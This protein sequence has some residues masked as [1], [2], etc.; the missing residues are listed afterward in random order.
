MWDVLYGQGNLATVTGAI[1]FP[2]DCSFMR[3]PKFESATSTGSEQA[4]STTVPRRRSRHRAAPDIFEGHL[5]FWQ[6]VEFSPSFQ[7]DSLIAAAKPDPD[8]A[9]VDVG[10]FFPRTGSCPDR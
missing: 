6:F 3:A 10:E 5:A 7:F 4:L 2:V 9:C 1:P 8:S